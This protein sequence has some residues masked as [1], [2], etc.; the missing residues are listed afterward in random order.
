MNMIYTRYKSTED[1]ID[2]LKELKGKTK[3]KIL[4]KIR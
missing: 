1:M 4:R 2:E 3:K